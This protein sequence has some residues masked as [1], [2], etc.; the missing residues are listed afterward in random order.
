[1]VLADPA[2]ATPDQQ[3]LLELIDM[4]VRISVAFTLVLTAINATL[5]V[6][7]FVRM[8]RPKPDA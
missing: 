3:D 8:G 5:E 4:I 6:R 2:T 1:M 7:R